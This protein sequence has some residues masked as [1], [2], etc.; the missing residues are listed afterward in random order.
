[1]HKTSIFSAQTSG[2]YLSLTPTYEWDLQIF[3]AVALLKLPCNS[4]ELN[5][6]HV[7]PSSIWHTYVKMGATFFG[8]Y[9][10]EL[11]GWTVEQDVLD[12]SLMQPAKKGSDWNRA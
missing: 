12:S 9:V 3:L 10:L 5:E 7:P 6:S 8:R 2:L 1:M 11:K 4:I